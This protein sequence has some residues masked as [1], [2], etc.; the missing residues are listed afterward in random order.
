MEEE[1]KKKR[2]KRLT[3][4]EEEYAL[5]YLFLYGFAGGIMAVD[6]AVKRRAAEKQT[7]NYSI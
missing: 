4:K 6:R 7:D 1:P 5:L 3:K 2:G